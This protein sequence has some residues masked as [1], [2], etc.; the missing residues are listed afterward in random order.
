[1]NNF[2]RNCKNYPG[3]GNICPKSGKELK[4]ILNNSCCYFDIT[5]RLRDE[6]EFIQPGE[7]LFPEKKMVEFLMKDKMG[8]VTVLDRQPKGSTEGIGLVL[9][10][11]KLKKEIGNDCPYSYRYV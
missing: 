7:P 3:K 4:D 1:M 9:E 11:M 2:C 8:N 5:D 10:V 6:V